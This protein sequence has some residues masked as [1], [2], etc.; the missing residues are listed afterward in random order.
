MDPAKTNV[1]D[2]MKPH[3]EFDGTEMCV[4]AGE[5]SWQDGLA[6]VH[7]KI[8]EGRLEAVIQTV[9]PKDQEEW[10][11]CVV[12]TAEAKTVSE[13]PRRRPRICTRLEPLYPWPRGVTACPAA[14]CPV[15]VGVLRQNSSTS[16]A[17]SESPS[18][19]LIQLVLL[20]SKNGFK[21]WIGSKVVTALVN[22]ACSMAT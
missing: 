16:L 9:Q 8:F 19:S 4:T 14:D 6:E 18:Y 11:E 22:L 17:S 12:A 13:G 7:G 5:A 2:M 10:E 20:W 1:S 3:F 15:L 21:V